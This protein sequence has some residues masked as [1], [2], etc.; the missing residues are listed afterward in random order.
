MP[1]TVA[2]TYYTLIAF[3]PSGAKKL[4]TK[5]NRSA[6]L[7]EY[8]IV[9]RSAKAQSEHKVNLRTLSARTKPFGPAKKQAKSAPDKK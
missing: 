7:N 1:R 8:I 6:C 5:L 9:L 3:V 2:Y 4:C